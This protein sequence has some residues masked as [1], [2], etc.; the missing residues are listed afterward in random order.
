MDDN[1][2]FVIAWS[3]IGGSTSY[4][5]Y[6]QRYSASGVALEGNVRVNTQTA[7]SQK[8]P[9][10]AMDADGDFVVTWTGFRQDIPEWSDVYARK[11]NHST[12]A[13]GSD[14]IVNTHQ[15]GTHYR[16]SIAMGP[17]GEFVIAWTST[18]QEPPKPFKFVDSG[19]YAQRFNAA[20]QPQGQEF[21][22]N[23]E[24]DGSQG[25]PSVSMNAVR[26]FVITG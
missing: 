26:E 17:Q 11:F 24:T 7:G 19:I 12:S 16:S 15:G 21:H 14:F 8:Y 20:A 6:A 23:T 13:W 25:F 1:G 3:N 22:V 10:V 18:I 2:D 5:V 4:D 9:L